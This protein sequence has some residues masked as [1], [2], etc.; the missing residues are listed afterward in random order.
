MEITQLKDR[1]QEMLTRDGN[2]TEGREGSQ[3]LTP[4]SR[5]FADRHK[6]QIPAQSRNADHHQRF[7][8]IGSQQVKADWSIPL[9][10]TLI[11]TRTKQ[12]PQELVTQ[13]LSQVISNT[14]YWSRG[15]WAYLASGTRTYL[16]KWGAIRDKSKS[17][18]EPLLYCFV[19]SLSTDL[20][21]LTKYPFEFLI[22]I[23]DSYTIF[24]I[25]GAIS[26][27]LLFGER[28]ISQR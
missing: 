22:M 15:E 28:A 8:P 12:Q 21:F 7:H 3:R 4:K 19:P 10:S 1:N 27:V 23:S 17:G 2:P 9:Q 13:T 6:S 25:L 16:I 14:Y 11:G 18:D 26:K 20:I 5:R 24:I